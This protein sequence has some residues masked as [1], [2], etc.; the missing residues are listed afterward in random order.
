M[1]EVSKS[2]YYR[3]C[4]RS[5]SVRQR[6]NEQL[7]LLI[8]E[9]HTVSQKRYGSP[10]VH[11]ELRARG[12]ACGRHRVARLMQKACLCGKVRRPKKFNPCPHD[13]YPVAVDYVQR[14]FKA[15]APKR[16]WASDITY[17]ATQEGYVYVVIILD[18]FS[19]RIVGYCIA[20]HL[21]DDIVIKAFEEAVTVRRPPRGLIFHSDR[22]VQYASHRFQGQLKRHG[23]IS[24]MSRKGNCLDNAV[25]ESFFHTLKTE[26][27]VEENYPTVEDARRQVFEYLFMF[28]N[29][30]RLH[31]FLGYQTPAEFEANYCE[32]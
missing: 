17:L 3:Y 24:S 28:Y 32:A 7:S 13:S 25:A 2:G 26:L 23:A 11:A 29:N 9:I 10:R 19:R 22:G 14:N 6:T 12:I 4:S 18:L 30:Q 5:P 21:R 8:R 20:T 31:S 15:T 16:V 1:L 27:S